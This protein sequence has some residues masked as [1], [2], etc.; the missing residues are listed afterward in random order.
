MLGLFS[1]MT[2]LA[3]MHAQK[4]K[5]LFRKRHGI[6]NNCRPF[7]TSQFYDE[8]RKVPRLGS[9]YHCCAFLVSF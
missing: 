6:A 4:Q 7:R 1:I 2:I 9:A 3:N 5:L 8:I